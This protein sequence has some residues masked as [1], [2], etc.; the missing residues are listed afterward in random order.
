[1]KKS[2]ATVLLSALLIQACAT[3]V[4]NAD[5]PRSP[6]PGDVTE[7]STPMYQHMRAMQ[8]QMTAIRAEQNPERRAAPMMQHMEAMKEG[9]AMMDHAA[10][11]TANMTMEERMAR[12][13]QRMGMMQ[14]MMGQ[15]MEQGGE[16]GASAEHE[17]AQ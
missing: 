15:M 9:M 7:A 10:M 6:T 4:E 8:T 1:M 5:A 16:E 17:H 2:L 13:E 11:D 12:M 3:A 14:M